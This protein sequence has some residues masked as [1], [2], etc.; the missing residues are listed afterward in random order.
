MKGT[1]GMIS[2]AVKS[3]RQTPRGMPQQQQEYRAGNA[4]A[5][6]VVGGV[7]ALGGAAMFAKQHQH[8]HDDTHGKAN[9]AMDKTREAEMHLERAMYELNQARKDMEVADGLQGQMLKEAT[10]VGDHAN[11]SGATRTLYANK[12][13][14]ADHDEN[15]WHKDPN[16]QLHRPAWD[17][18]ISCE[19]GH[20]GT[21]LHPANVDE[22]SPDFKP[23]HPKKEPEN[24]SNSFWHSN[25]S[26]K[27]NSSSS[28]H[29]LSNEM[30][31]S[32][33][34]ETHSW[35]WGSKEA[36]SDA[37]MSHAGAHAAGQGPAAGSKTIADTSIIKE[38]AE[39]SANASIQSS[40][41]AETNMSQGATGRRGS[42]LTGWLRAG[43]ADRIGDEK[44][45]GHAVN[46]QVFDDRSL[47]SGKSS[48]SSS[49]MATETSAPAPVNAGT[50]SNAPV[51]T[52]AFQRAE[53]LT[54]SDANAQHWWQSAKKDAKDMTDYAARDAQN[55]ADD[56]KN[57]ATDIKNKATDAANDGVDKAKS[58]WSSAKH[59]AQD[60]TDK[61]ERDSQKKAFEMESKANDIT[62]DVK[63]TTTDA[64][65][66]GVDKA[67]SWWS[68]VK[69]DAQDTTDN[70][71]RD[72]QKM[73]NEMES[74]ANDITETANDAKNMATDAVNEGVDKA[75]SWWSSAK[76]EAQDTTDKVERDSQK[77]AYEMQSKAN[78]ITDTADDAAK[79]GAEKVKSWWSST[80]QEVQDTAD[81]A[82]RDAQGKANELKR[83]AE[84]SANEDIGGSRPSKM[85]RT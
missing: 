40:G 81:Q 4:A 9:V 55:K 24:A 23:W 60:T 73:A 75:K 82:T 34:K 80:K 36:A 26:P 38:S 70:V 33:T 39:S 3:I 18:R 68:S 43:S 35:F 27:D 64:V 47:L 63:N 83:K 1:S 41:G 78:D 71:E 5:P 61:V 72:S 84:D 6:L 2:S 77:K 22:T 11:A 28:K 56:V 12:N 21:A 50:T 30:D 67:K 14:S 31:T 57:K 7:L 74:K 25:A 20:A 51:W 52:T 76:H 59:D 49:S 17:K 79:D 37:T 58:W 8:A 66:D 10:L 85:R 15:H 48:P 54:K 29:A 69:R 19:H 46:S 32:S 13:A 53:E 65:N 42:A 62:D 16:G 44:E 45:P